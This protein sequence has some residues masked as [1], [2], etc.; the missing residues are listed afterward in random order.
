MPS[1]GGRHGEYMAEGSVYSDDKVAAWVKKGDAYT[2][3]YSARVTA[4]EEGMILAVD[5]HPAH[6]GE[7]KRFGEDLRPGISSSSGPSCRSGNIIFGFEFKRQ[8]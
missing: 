6:T 1:S 2:Y 7:I 4:D 3:G 8:R 5:T